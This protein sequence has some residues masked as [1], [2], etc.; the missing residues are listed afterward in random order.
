ML[1][2][3][4]KAQ[5][6]DLNKQ[7]FVLGSAHMTN[8]IEALESHLDTEPYQAEHKMRCYTGDKK[9]ELQ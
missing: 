5:C 3:L 2:A 6:G 7:L 1:K 4:V 9:V 8:I